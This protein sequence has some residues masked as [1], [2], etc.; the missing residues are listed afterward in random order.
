MPWQDWIGPLSVVFLAYTVLGVTGFGSALLAVPLLSWKWP[1]QEVVVLILL[2]DIVGTA[3]HGGLNLRQVQK[4]LVLQMLP[5]I[6][7]GAL[8]GL[9]L[10]QILNTRW[11]I[12]CLGAYV[13]LVGLR[14]LWSIE[15]PSPANTKPLQSDSH[16]GSVFIG[17]VETVFATSGPV[18]LATLKNRLT[19]L[20]RL[21]ATVPV[22]LL[23]ASLIA[24]TVLLG[25]GQ[26]A[27]GPSLERFLW[28]LPFAVLGILL[29]NHLAPRIPQ[30]RMR[31]LLAMLLILSGIAL[32]A[33]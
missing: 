20:A 31:Q 23:M 2:L 10:S 3:L 33:H 27:L 24:L 28:S 30:M 26:V 7:L 11:P 14:W 9:W 18:V 25:S 16:V 5:G 13:A 32:M 22:V 29:G 8:I 6:A 1:L 15:S 21:R 12:L 4:N 19:D 17:L